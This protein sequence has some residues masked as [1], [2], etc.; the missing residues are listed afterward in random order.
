MDSGGLVQV[1]MYTVRTESIDP[2]HQGSGF[3]P[4]PRDPVPDGVS[5]LVVKLLSL[6]GITEDVPDF[7]PRVGMR[8]VGRG[9]PWEMGLCA[10]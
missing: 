1:W 6:Q 7:C 8:I 10:T 2:P 9:G 5:L 4:C 3:V